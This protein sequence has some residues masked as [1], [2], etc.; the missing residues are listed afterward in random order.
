MELR[1]KRALGFNVRR[2]YMRKLIPLVVLLFLASC[3]DGGNQSSVVNLQSS[4]GSGVQAADEM[5]GLETAPPTG[6]L[7]DEALVE[8][9]ALPTPEGVNEALFALS[10]IHI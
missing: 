6:V 9:D 5:G 7:L 1:G 3:G 10:L 8:L 2:T 4:E